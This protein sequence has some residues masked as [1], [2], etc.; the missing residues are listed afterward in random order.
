MEEIAK[1]TSDEI[2]LELSNMA[3]GE[4]AAKPDRK[5]GAAQ[6]TEGHLVYEIIIPVENPNLE[7][8]PGLRGFAKIH[9][10]NYTFAWWLLRWWNK[11][12]NFQL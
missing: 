4:I 10:G 2:P 8:E 3:E 7:L 6:P 11:V 9:G 5:T 12:F 1:H